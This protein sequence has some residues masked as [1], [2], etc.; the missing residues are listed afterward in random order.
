MRRIALA[1]LLCASLYGCGTVASTVGAGRPLVYGGVRSDWL[2]LTYED[3]P[4]GPGPSPLFVVA[5]LLD[6][7]LSAALD[8]ALLPVSVPWELADED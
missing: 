1:L 2:A 5:A 7:P 6:L 4:V 3:G 8:T